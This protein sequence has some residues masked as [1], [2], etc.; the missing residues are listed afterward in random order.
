MKS[1]SQSLILI[2]TL[3]LLA[4]LAITSCGQKALDSDDQV[5]T[6]FY[7]DVKAQ[8]LPDREKFLNFWFPQITIGGVKYIKEKDIYELKFAGIDWETTEVWLYNIK[9]STIMPDNGTA[10]LTAIYLFC[11]GR[12]DPKE[13]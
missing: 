6:S 7:E 3:V 9:N 8:A 12:S 5:I 4:S 11:E 2:I 10:L 13:V 1:K